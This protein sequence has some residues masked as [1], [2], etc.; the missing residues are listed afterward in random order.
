MGHFCK[1]TLI[2]KLL[3]GEGCLDCANIPSCLAV[4]KIMQIFTVAR[5]MQITETLSKQQIH[6]CQ[7]SL[8][9]SA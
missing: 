7:I 8:M 1:T 2:R 3:S 4:D 5:C 6:S 9:H